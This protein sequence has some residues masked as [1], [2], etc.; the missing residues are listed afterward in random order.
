M[1]VSAGVGLAQL[2]RLKSVAPTG[3][4]VTSASSP[5]PEID[6]QLLSELVEDAW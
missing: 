2:K 1:I 6:T 4:W 3:D 5:T